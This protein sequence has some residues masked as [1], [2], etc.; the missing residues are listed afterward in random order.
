MTTPTLSRPASDEYASYYTRY[1]ERVPEGELPALLADQLPKMLAQL[2]EIPES[3]GNHRYAPDKWSIKDVIQHVIDAERIFTYRA[4]R[5]ARGDRTPLPGWEENEYAPVAQAD[6][7]T[8]ADLLDELGHVRRATIALFS[9]FDD[10]ALT[11][12]G[13][14][15]T[16]D[17]TVRAL[18]YIAIGHATHHLAILRERYL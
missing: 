13:N 11:R 14:A 9:H 17:V 7:R 1:V 6:R 4:L 18:G 16:F 15:S 12:R 3:R 8:I 10:A 2:E 5:I